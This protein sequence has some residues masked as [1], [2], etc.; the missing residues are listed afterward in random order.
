MLDVVRFPWLADRAIG[1]LSRDR[2]L[3]QKFL[4]I[5]AGTRRFGEITLRDR[6]AL[7][8]G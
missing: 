5:A 3:F 6:L 2:D 4:G 1:R 8:L 7:A